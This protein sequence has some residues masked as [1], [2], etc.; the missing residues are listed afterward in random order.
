LVQK[1]MHAGSVF[2]CSESW[3][4]WLPMFYSY[5]F[6]T[7]PPFT[8]YFYTSLMLAKEVF[9]SS[10]NTEGENVGSNPNQWII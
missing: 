6:K 5:S 3:H 1:P 10:Q 2:S 7:T 9:D 4:Q 8:D